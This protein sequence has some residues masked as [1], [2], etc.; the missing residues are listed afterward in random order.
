VE[1]VVALRVSQ[2]AYSSCLRAYHSSQL[3]K[4]VAFFEGMGMGLRKQVGTS[5]VLGKQQK[6]GEN[7][8]HADGKMFNS[9]LNLQPIDGRGLRLKALVILQYRHCNSS[10]LL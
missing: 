6:L 8:V 4:E 2:E 1:P 3:E 7:D 10:S 5:K 9:L